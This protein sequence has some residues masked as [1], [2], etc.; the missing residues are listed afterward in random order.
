MRRDRGEWLKMRMKKLITALLALCMLAALPFAAKTPAYAEGEITKVLA[1]TSYTPVALMDVSFI[2]AAT[3]TDGCY[4]TSITWYDQNYTPLTDKFG[5]DTYHLEIRLDACEG[6][7][8]AEG[9]SAYLNNSAVDYAIGEGGTY[10]VLRRDYTPA[11]WAPNIIK[12][13]G[14]ETVTEG[15]WAS[16]VST[17]SYADSCSWSLVDPS[18]RSI[19][20]ADIGSK[21]PSVTVGGDG[22]D[23]IIVR[24]IPLEMNGWKAVCTFSGP[25]GSV[26][27]NGAVIKVNPDPAK[28]TPTP[29]PTPSAEASEQPEESP[30]PT[31][32]VHTHE[33]ADTWQSDAGHH[34]RQCECGEMTDRAEHTM[35]WKTILEAEKN[36]PGEEKGVCSVCGYTS[37]RELQ[38]H[39]SDKGDSPSLSQSVD[40]GTFRI[41]L[42]VLMG[43]L[44]AG[45][46]ALV[47][48]G[49]VGGRRGRH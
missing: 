7:Y 8:F 31:E 41:I 16:F 32:E 14:G 17:A 46:V 45:V 10:I 22:T 39:G 13:P 28:A 49:I 36:S 21:F 19:S 35:E 1:T 43:L 23:K 2:S 18:G 40:L 47:V 3:S 9:L 30:E 34:W 29:S 20:C 44:A 5:T 15:G 4:A 25:G 42:Y 37:S 24:G 38:Y 27:S 12:H 26:T 33:F 48:R 11:I 6:R